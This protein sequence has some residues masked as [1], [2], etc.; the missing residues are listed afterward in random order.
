MSTS[1]DECLPRPSLRVRRNGAFAGLCALTIVGMAGVSSPA[2]AAGT[3]TKVAQLP[4]GGIAANIALLTDGRV[5]MEGLDDVD[6]ASWN[7]WW[8]L[9]PDS[10]GSYENGTWTKVAKSAYGRV[11]NPA[12][13]LN[14]G[15][16]F[17]CGGEYNCQDTPTGCTVASTDKSTCEVYDPVA[18]TWTS[19]PDMPGTVA[20]TPSALMPDGRVLILSYGPPTDYLFDI[21]LKT[22]VRAADYRGAAV[23][24]EGGSLLLPDGSALVGAQQYDRYSYDQWTQ[25]ASTATIPGGVATGEFLLSPTNAEI[26]PFVLLHDGRA[27][28][29]GGNNRNGLYDYRTNTWS[30]TDNTPVG[31]DPTKP[32]NHADA[33][34]SVEPDGKV[35]TI[36]TDDQTGVGTTQGFFYE[37]DPY[38]SAGSRWSPVAFPPVTSSLSGNPER[39]RI[40]PLPSGKLLFTTVEDNG[41]VW[42]YTP[43]GTPNS[44]WRPTIAATPVLIFGNYLLDGTQLSGL[45]TGGDFGDDGKV[46]TNYPI[47]SL[48]AGSQITYA[49]SFGF[50]QMAPRPAKN[51]SC[52]F[53]LPAGLPNGTYNVHVNANGVDSTNTVPLTIP[54][55]DLGPALTAGLSLLA[56]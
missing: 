16:Y 55:L 21:I 41:T 9:A 14:G 7:A 17:L 46:A 52:W 2:N 29:L 45:T 54:A 13:V 43:A 37:Y 25:T 51:G 49:R 44:A 4:P 15:Q 47:V 50:D 19:M 42:L 31:P 35:F 39:T 18:N 22:W 48:V 5:L 11:F 3:W 38:A 53:H 28:I 36:V 8:T 10:T 20:D 26:G 6:H 40:M 1:A 32:Y 33:P 23:S 24:N 12:F 56:S 30:L 34:S 27:L